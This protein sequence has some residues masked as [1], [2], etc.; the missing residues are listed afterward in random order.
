MTCL[1]CDHC[2]ALC[3]RYVALP[4]DTPR[5]KRDF[6]DIRWYLMH[7][8]ISIF[9]EDGDWYINIMAR[10]KN[11]QPDNRC[12]IYDTRPHICQEYKAGDCDYIGVEYDYDHLFTDVEQLDAFA[13]E[14]LR[15]R[16]RRSRRARRGKRKVP[17]KQ[18]RK[19]RAG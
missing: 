2:T 14:Y 9:V 4:I 12:A 16:R 3:C 17:L 18:R 10:C 13:A 1:L 7:E 8:G 15:G 19:R 5:T 11:L 6:D